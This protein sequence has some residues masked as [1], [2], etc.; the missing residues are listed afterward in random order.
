MWAS[1]LSLKGNVG[2]IPQPGCGYC[3]AT[4]QISETHSDAPGRVVFSYQQMGTLETDHREIGETIWSSASFFEASGM[5]PIA[6]E[7]PMDSF[8]LTSAR[9]HNRIRS[10]RLAASGQ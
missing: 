10:P 2:N 9:T 1:P 7:I 3:L 8:I 5:L 6:P 4:Q